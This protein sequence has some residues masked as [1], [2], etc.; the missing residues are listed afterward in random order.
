MEEYRDIKGYEGFYQVSNLGEVK[1]LARFTIQSNGVKYPIKEK[2][3]KLG[4]G[5]V[6]LTANLY[7][8]GVSKT[9]SVHTLVAA[10][11]LNHTPNRYEGLIVDHID[12][13]P[14]NNRVENLQLVTQRYNVSKDSKG[15]SE[16]V[17]VSWNK[18]A[19]KWCAN[20]YINGSYKFLGSF[21]NEL[22][23]SKAYQKELQTL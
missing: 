2:T 6:Y 14:L 23:A 7:K 21:S 1:S 11:F 3:L 13:D 18:Q 8:G 22:E 15:S 5:S 12:N 9:L 4:R 17:G 16:Y 19:N 20:V 10:A